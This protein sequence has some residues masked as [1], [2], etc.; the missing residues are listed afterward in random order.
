MCMVKKRGW[1]PS[2]IGT[3]NKNWEATS[4]SY[5]GHFAAH[6]SAFSKLVKSKLES[7]AQEIMYS[8]QEA[9]KRCRGKY[10]WKFK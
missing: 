6:G 8:Q 9:E 7:D 4:K 1:S 3:E 2:E 10:F 5:N